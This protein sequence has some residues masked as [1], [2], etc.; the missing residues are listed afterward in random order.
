MDMS[1]LSDLLLQSTSP[2]F[3][4]PPGEEVVFEGDAVVFPPEGGKGKLSR[5]ERIRIAK[6]KRAEMEER[7][8]E[9]EGGGKEGMVKE[10]KDV[11]GVMRQRRGMTIEGMP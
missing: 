8:A 2:D 10:L 7:R 3:L 4:P 6:E 1:H 9:G 11:L 5:E